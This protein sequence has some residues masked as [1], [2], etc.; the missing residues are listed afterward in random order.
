MKKVYAFVAVIV[1]LCALFAPIPAYANSAIRDFEGTDASGVLLTDQDCPVTVTSEKLTFNIESYPKVYEENS[2]Y[3][4]NVIA[5]YS[6]YNPSDYDVS[7]QLVFPFGEVPSYLSYGDFNDSEKYGVYIND[8]E[9]SKILRATYSRDRFDVKTDLAKISDEPIPLFG[10]TDDTTVYKYEIVSTFEEVSGAYDY[11]ADFIVEGRLLFCNTDRY[12]DSHHSN[13]IDYIKFVQSDKFVVYS[14]GEELSEQFFSPTYYAIFEKYFDTEE[15]LTGGS[16]DYTKSTLTL[17]ELL[18]TY[19]KEDMG[20]SQMDYR[21]AVVTYLQESKSTTLVMG[22]GYLNMTYGLLCWYQYDVTI[23]SKQSVTNKVIAPLYPYVNEYYEPPKYSYTYLLSP[24]NCWAD[25]ANLDVTINS[26]SF[27]LECNQEGFSKTDNGYSAH[28]DSLPKGE[29]IF[30]LCASENPK[31]VG[32]ET[33]GKVISGIAIAIGV[34]ALLI[35]IVGPIIIAVTILLVSRNKRKRKQL[36]AQGDSQT[37]SDAQMEEAKKYFF[38]D[39]SDKK[40]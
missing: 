1:L 24:A 26:G 2:D 16:T 5:E 15:R 17:S 35:F 31:D 22:L 7:M 37:C 14:V 12:Y 32:L 28:F 25:F 10:Y 23:P 30:T 3:N 33:F 9:Q 20:V 4:A 21:N 8:V 13:G 19:Y 11:A 29:L 38:N 27:M 18:L 34:I 39:D 40:L 36:E 6:F